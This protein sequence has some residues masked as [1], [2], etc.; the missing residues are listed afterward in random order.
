MSTITEP[1]R[2][3][4][5]LFETD[6]V[7]AG[8]GIS[9]VSAAVAS[10]R[11]GAKTIL[12]EQTGIIG[13]V[14]VAGLV[15][16]IDNRYITSEDRMVIKGIMEEVVERCVKRGDA[17]PDW[18]TPILTH[19]IRNPEI[20]QLVLIDMLGE[21]GVKVLL[22]T[23][24]TDVIL[25]GGNVQGVIIESKV[26][27]QAILS[28]VTVD[29][30][31]DAYLAAKSGTPCHFSPPGSSSMCFRMGNVDIQKTFEYFQEHPEECAFKSDFVST[32]ETME[33][34]WTKRG[35][36]HVAHG[37]GKTIKVIQRAIERGEYA[38]EKKMAVD[39]DYFGMW[40]DAKN[41]TMMINSNF[42]RI[43]DLDIELSSK[44]EME[45]RELCHET[46][47][48]LC[49][50]MPGFE[51]AYLVQTAPSL[52]I[53]YMRWIKAKCALSLEDLKDGRTFN[54]S[55]GMSVGWIWLPEKDGKLQRIVRLPQPVEIPYRILI[56][57]K[58]DNLLV[59][60]GKTVS[61][62]ERGIMRFQADCMVIGQAAGTAA[63]L[64]ALEEIKPRD[65]KI[66]KLQRTLLNQGVYLGYDSRLKQLELK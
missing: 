33:Q 7:V 52:G 57:Q 55:V 12:L 23:R 48:F 45:S 40:G 34:N 49:K 35:L 5:V 54:D 64:S 46:A 11:T 50:V 14:T 1:A 6:V 44:A 13:G 28:K 21:A 36:F 27:R 30:T 22:N 26:G 8:A 58:V 60:S 3:I 66:K 24:V 18:R 2:Q 62:V 20:L 15:A 31:G 41:N 53:R 17:S 38:R 61:V 51:N 16:T 32:F 59:G 4:P 39:M 37:G 43:N 65:L 10:A 19:A 9:G 63:A 42:H 25:D 47:N 56:P 29:A